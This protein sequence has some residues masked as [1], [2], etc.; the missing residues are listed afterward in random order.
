MELPRHGGNLEEMARI[1]GCSAQE[2]LDFSANINPLG[3]PEWFRPLMEQEIGH[4]SHYPDPSY[5]RV[6]CAV[7][8]R[9][10]LSPDEIA[11]GNG[12]SELLFAIPRVLRPPWAVVPVPCYSDYHRALEVAEIPH[13]SLA[14]R[15]EVAFAVDPRALEAAIDGQPPGGLVVTGHPSNPC[16]TL[17]DPTRMLRL[18]SRHPQHWFL[19]DEAFIDFCAQEQSLRAHRPPNVI[20][21]WSLTKILAIPGLRAGLCLASAAI[22]KR[23]TQTLPPWS[24]NHLA[25]VTLERAMQ[26]LDYVSRAR[27]AVAGWRGQLALDL[28]SLGTLKVFPGAANYLLLKIRSSVTAADLRVRLL[29]EHRIG[30]RD[31]SSYAA[32]DSS[33]MRVAVR[34]PSENARLVQALRSVLSSVGTQ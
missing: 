34:T 10:A 19:V 13:T 9:F 1:A 21:L 32:L 31:C 4:L 26:D 18:A 20:I 33:Y 25:C 7:G 22:V 8:R 23:L 30:V 28:D 27:S 14:G 11:L 24:V 16:G 3:L 6:R 17:L 15:E 5:E 29:R 2:I 12:S